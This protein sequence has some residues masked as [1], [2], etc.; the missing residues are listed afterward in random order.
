MKSL[1]M[2]LL[3][4]TLSVAHADYFRSRVPS[5]TLKN[6]DVITESGG[7]EKLWDLLEANK[8]LIFVPGYFS[9]NSSCPLVVENL[10]ASL[11]GANLFRNVQVLFLSFN[12]TDKPGDI[13]MFREHHGVPRDWTMAII[14]KEAA[15]KELLASFQYLF[16]KTKN[17]FDHPNAVYVFSV[18][19]KNWSGVLSGINTTPDDLKTA[20]Q[21]AKFADRKDGWAVFQRTATQPE[22]LILFGFSVIVLSLVFTILFIARKRKYWEIERPQP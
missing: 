3:S 10:K 22:N 20:L 5:A 1:S 16:Q 6:V 12:D 14:Q 21:D 18:K 17:G 2:L 19:D 8:A 9:C 7:S 11:E 15:A 4:L 13:K